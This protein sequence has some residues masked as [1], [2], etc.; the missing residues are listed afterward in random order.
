MNIEGECQMVR[1]FIGEHERHEGKPLYEAIVEK[2]ESAGAAGVT[3]FR[4][5][6]GF[7]A[8]KHVHKKRPFQYSDDLPIMI[9]FI[10][11]EDR[12]GGFL[13]QVEPLV[14]RGLILKDAVNVVVYR[15]EHEHN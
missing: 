1:V 11:K 9:E 12:M 6:E 4:G 8:A 5:I 14:R 2:L 15:H 13:A 10:D 7:G 3:V